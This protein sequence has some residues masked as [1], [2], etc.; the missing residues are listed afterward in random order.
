MKNC[1]IF[2]FW[3]LA[4]S[5]VCIP[6]LFGHFQSQT[7]APRNALFGSLGHSQ[8]PIPNVY[9]DPIAY[10]TDSTTSTI[11]LIEPSRASACRNH[12][13]HVPSST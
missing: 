5:N 13:H 6:K 11:S 7:S 9:T 4:C 2:R 8:L 12:N 3:I 1:E 10:A